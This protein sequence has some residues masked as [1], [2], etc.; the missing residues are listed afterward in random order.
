MGGPGSLLVFVS[1]CKIASS[2]EAGAH[3]SSPQGPFQASSRAVRLALEAL[4]QSEEDK[5]RG[6]VSKE[7]CRVATSS[8]SM[9][10]CTGTSALRGGERGSV[11]DEARSGHEPGR[12][13]AGGGERLAY[14]C[15]WVPQVLD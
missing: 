13:V 4:E 15:V 2:T 1:S 8:S 3:G 6:F 9:L 12:R 11:G 5:T 10:P 14:G 7:W